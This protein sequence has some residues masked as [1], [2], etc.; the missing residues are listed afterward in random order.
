MKRCSKSYV[1]R[2]FHIKTTKYHSTHWPE[3]PKSRIPN[4]C[5][6]VKQWELS[7]IAKGNTKWYITVEFGSFL[8]NE[9]ESYH[10]IQQPHSMVFTQRRWKLRPIK[11]LEHERLYQNLVE[12]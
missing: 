4:A 6:G 5:E 3:W 11:K 10:V 1:F 2:E 7:L 8:Q 9:A 12:T